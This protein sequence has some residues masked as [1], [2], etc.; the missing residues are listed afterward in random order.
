MTCTDHP[1]SFVVYSASAIYIIG[2]PEMMQDFHI[3][4]QEALLGLSLYVFACKQSPRSLLW[5]WQYAN[6]IQTV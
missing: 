3:S 2:I 4:E 5:L 6:D 1:T